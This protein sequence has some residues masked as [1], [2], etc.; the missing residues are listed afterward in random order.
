MASRHKYVDQAD[1]TILTRNDLSRGENTTGFA[2]TYE[3]RHDAHVEPS[4][5][6]STFSLFWAHV[7]AAPNLEKEM[8]AF[9]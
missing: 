8:E 7:H 5:R 1:Q 2:H 6:T 4:V 3:N 9:A